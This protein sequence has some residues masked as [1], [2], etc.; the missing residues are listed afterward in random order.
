MKRV[1]ATA[2]LI[3]R[4][5]TGEHT[6]EPHRIVDLDDAV[7]DSFIASGAAILIA[8]E[9]PAVAEEISPGAL[10]EEDEAPVSPK[11]GKRR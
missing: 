4:T 8:V 3:H 6:V 7:A 1:K 10:T 9:A 2:A 11:F 5:E